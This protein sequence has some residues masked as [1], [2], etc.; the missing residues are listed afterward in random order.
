MIIEQHGNGVDCCD[1][2]CDTLKILI[3]YINI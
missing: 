2:V 1:S 3:M